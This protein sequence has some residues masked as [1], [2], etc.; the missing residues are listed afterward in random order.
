MY[1]AYIP[2]RPAAYLSR[3]SETD[4]KRKAKP[5]VDRP[6]KVLPIGKGRCFALDLEQFCSHWN[7]SEFGDGE[8][9]SDFPSFCNAIAGISLVGEG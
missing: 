3:I 9:G 8:D 5:P 6:K 7:Y 1:E 4:N 2:S